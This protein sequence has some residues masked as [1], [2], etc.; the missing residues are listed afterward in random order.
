MNDP[1]YS[2]QHKNFTM[3]TYSY[4]LRFTYSW[5]HIFSSTS[6]LTHTYSRTLVDSIMSTQRYFY[7]VKWT[8]LH[9]RNSHK[10]LKWNYLIKKA[11]F[12]FLVYK[13]TRMRTSDIETLYDCRNY[14][15]VRKIVLVKK[16][17]STFVWLEKHS[18]T[19]M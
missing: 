9:K 14:A 17:V 12:F 10:N 1:Q 5:I 8:N 16:Q 7:F 3:F 19:N 13:C 2:R 6:I 4:P 18:Y 11:S 15:I